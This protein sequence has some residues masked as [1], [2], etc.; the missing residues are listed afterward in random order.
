MTYASFW[1]RLYAALLDGSILGILIFFIEAFTLPFIW[2]F[3]ADGDPH[4]LLLT[5]AQVYTVFGWILLCAFCCYLLYFIIAECSPWQGSIGKK[6]FGLRITDLNGNRIGLFRILLRRILSI[7]S[8]LPLGFGYIMSFF[9]EKHQCL[10]DKYTHCLV[11]DVKP[12]KTPGCASG[13]LMFLWLIIMSGWYLP[14]SIA[15]IVAFLEGLQLS[16]EKTYAEQANILL[17]QVAD[18]Q[19]VYAQNH[20]RYATQWQ[21]LQFADCPPTHIDR[22]KPNQCKMGHFN[23]VLEPTAVVAF[24]IPQE[25]DF[26]MVSPYKLSRPYLPAN[27]PVVC[28]TL[29]PQSNTCSN[30]NFKV[31]PNRSLEN[32]ARTP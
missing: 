8:L 16:D 27:A 13:I 30:L 26:G 12:F 11:E 3:V 25:K 7:V 6:V 31:K 28:Q 29:V 23:F 32:G 19:Q 22:Q 21:Q 9:S 20:F 5:R 10:H 1:K 14:A 18:V 4:T 15:L 17:R 2:S 24:S